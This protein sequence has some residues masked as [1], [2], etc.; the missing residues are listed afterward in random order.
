MGEPPHNV[1]ACSTGQILVFEQNPTLAKRLAMAIWAKTQ[2]HPALTP[3]FAE[4]RY[5]L[6][7]DRGVVFAAA[8]NAQ[9]STSDDV[10][11]I[12]KRKGI[13]IVLY[14]RE[15]E[16]G[17]CPR[18]ANRDAV[19]VVVCAG[20][21]LVGEVA[22]AVSRLVEDCDR[23]LLVVDDSRSMRAALEQFLS[24]RGYRVLQACDGVQAL[25]V[26]EAHP[27]IRLVITDNEM[28][29]MDGFTLVKEI[30][31]RFS[32]DDLAVIGISAL[33][34]SS[35]L[36][37]R[38]INNGANDFLHKP[39]QREEL[40]CRVE[41]NL[42]MLRRI[43]IIRDLSYR[44]ALTRLHNRRYFFE[45]AGP[46]IDG[47]RR[48]GRE[49]C[50]AMLD[51]DQFKRVNDTH[52]HDAGDEVI[53]SVAA[54]ILAH[55]AKEAIASRFGGEEFCVLFKGEADAPAA[56]R[57]EALRRA[58]GQSVVPVDGNDIRVTVSTGYSCEQEPLQAM[59]KLADTRLYEAKTGG[60]DRV[61]GPEGGGR[62]QSADPVP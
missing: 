32:K 31:R 20:R 30:R 2:S 17:T 53:K 40:Y 42:E 33:D 18:P 36:S 14:A 6:E 37:V 12:L 52:G 15:T 54:H 38:F 59:L 8:V 60:R 22:E 45:N 46:F 57:L 28:P 23:P 47:V 39:F 13:P 49:Y 34:L 9:A 7:G 27:E 51:I 10:L 16:D 35:R 61:V 43:D 1:S 11:E 62:G 50:V 5:F 56:D 21:G 44:D 4:V 55:F 48:E 26:L 29:G 19:D 3:T 25:D 41:H 24:E 58:I